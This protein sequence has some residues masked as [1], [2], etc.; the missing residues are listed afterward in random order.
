[1]KQNTAISK[2]LAKPT[3]Y[4]LTTSG[5]IF[6]VDVCINGSQVIFQYKPGVYLKK[7]SLLKSICLLNT[8]PVITPGLLYKKHVA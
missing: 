7:L 5:T 8:L 3:V 1:M 4:T 2:H 6:S